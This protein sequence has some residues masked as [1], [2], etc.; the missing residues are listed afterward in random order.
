M[1][2][3]HRQRQALDAVLA[4]FREMG[5]PPSVRELATQLGLR[6]LASVHRLL[7][8]LVRRGFLRRV[9]YAPRGLAIPSAGLPSLACPACGK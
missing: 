3:T 4:A 6:S 7:N 2:L 9:P 5:R 8:G 1:Q